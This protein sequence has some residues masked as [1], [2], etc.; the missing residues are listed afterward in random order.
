MTDDL[1]KKWDGLLPTELPAGLPAYVT[2]DT[3]RKTIAQMLENEARHIDKVRERADEVKEKW[4]SND[5]DDL[6]DPGDVDNDDPM[7][8]EGSDFGTDNE[9]P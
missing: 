2:L 9:W 6:H 1:M 7:L 4:W 5:C 3:Y 8:D